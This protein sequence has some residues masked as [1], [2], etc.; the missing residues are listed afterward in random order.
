MTQKPV[1]L[2]FVRDFKEPIQFLKCLL[3]EEI[4]NHICNKTNPL[5]F[6][7]KEFKLSPNILLKF[8]GLELMRGYI[9]LRNIEMM[10]ND[11]EFSI[12]YPGKEFALYRKMWFAISKNLNFD[13]A[14]VHRSLVEEYKLHLVPGYNVTIDEVR[15]PCHHEECP[16]K[17]KNRD[18]PDIWAIESKTMHAENGYLIDFV[19][20]CQDKVPTPK[21]TVFQFAEFLKST[22]RRHHLVMDSNFLS[23][24]DLL[25]LYDMNF[26]A[27]ISCKSTRPSFIWKDG[28]AQKIPLSYSR[29]ASSERLCCV[30]T[31]NMGKPKIASTLCVAANE[32]S[33]SEVRER[34]DLLNI[35]DSLKGKADRFGQLY[36]CQYPI[37]YHKNW[38]TTLF[39]GWFYFT[40]TNSYI[41][42]DTQIG[43]LTHQEYVLQIAKDLI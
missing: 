21:E 28:L 26:E 22:E 39:F 15:I 43:G 18:K 38:K 3:S 19:N 35:Y 23:A 16:F 24:L 36:K 11:N 33:S 1:T 32:K 5:H 25:Q 42:Y 7:K 8:I 10:W 34:R 13:P 30:C 14:V 29:V 37:G 27:T 20:P 4:M 2:R 17:T 9:G 41:L 31:H 6:N 40:L 12:T